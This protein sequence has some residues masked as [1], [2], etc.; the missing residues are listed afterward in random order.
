MG[1]PDIPRDEAEVALATRREL[2]PEYEDAVV[3]SFAA[4]L[5]DAIDDRVAAEV[6]RRLGSAKQLRRQPAVEADQSKSALVVA[7]GSLGLAIPLLAVVS[8][9]HDP[10]YFEIA[11]VLA[12]VVLVNLAYNL[13]R[14]RR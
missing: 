7:L 4:K 10:S 11:V 1:T 8:G 2:G 14:L 13:A 9:E 6:E 12:T 5:D 3:D